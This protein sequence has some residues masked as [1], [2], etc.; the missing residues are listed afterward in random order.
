MRLNLEIYNNSTILDKT[1]INSITSTINH[2]IEVFGHPPP[3]CIWPDMS[4]YDSNISFS[5]V[6]FNIFKIM[7]T[8]TAVKYYNEQFLSNP[9][10]IDNLIE[11]TEGSPI[12]VPFN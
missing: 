11:V 6:H 1:E 4:N 10:N 8:K 3:E 2:Y 12:N 5:F 9:K 7:F